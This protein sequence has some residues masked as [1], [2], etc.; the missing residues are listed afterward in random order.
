MF[1]VTLT[2]RRRFFLGVALAWF[3]FALAFLAYW[4]RRGVGLPLLHWPF[5]ATLLWTLASA[6]AC[7]VVVA[8]CLGAM[9]RRRAPWTARRHLWVALLLALACFIVQWFSLAAGS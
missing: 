3:V 4:Q 7:G 1:F 8:E 9:A 5:A 2:P 6:L